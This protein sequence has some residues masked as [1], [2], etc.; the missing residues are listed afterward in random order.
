MRDQRDSELLALLRGVLKRHREIMR[1][2]ARYSA[3]GRRSLEDITERL[4]DPALRDRLDSRISAAIARR[5]ARRQVDPEH[6]ESDCVKLIQTL[7]GLELPEPLAIEIIQEILEAEATSKIADSTDLVRGI[8][9]LED[10]I[11]RDLLGVRQLPR[12]AKKKRKTKINWRIVALIAGIGLLAGNDHVPID[13]WC[14]CKIAV[15]LINYALRG[16]GGDD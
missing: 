16:K 13:H 6:N 9:E 14:I 1:G 12:K 10:E 7:A 3:L 11:S 8:Q 2:G 5:E 4:K 15:R